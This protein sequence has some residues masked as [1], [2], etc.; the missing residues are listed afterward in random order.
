SLRTPL[1][2]DNHT[3]LFRQY[4]DIK[5]K[6]PD[7]LLLFRLGDFYELFADDAV[8]AAETLH[9]TLTSR[10]AA[11]GER[12]P[13]CGVPFH[14]ADRYI[15]RLIAAGHRVAVCEQMEDARTAKQGLIRRKVTR[16]ITPGTVL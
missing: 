8:A 13:M 4:W 7:V 10:D 14:A 5:S 9:I 16:V 1:M 12:I 6:Y 15:A 3:P 2:S 11:R